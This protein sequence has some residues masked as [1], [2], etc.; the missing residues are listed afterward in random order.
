[1]EVARSLSS[2]KAQTAGEQNAVHVDG[3]ESALFDSA[4]D[5]ALLLDAALTL[6]GIAAKKVAN[7]PKKKDGFNL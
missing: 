2:E 7:L 3:A 5:S 4:Q 6:C 1:M